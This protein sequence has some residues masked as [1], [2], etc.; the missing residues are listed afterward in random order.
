MGETVPVPA[1]PARSTRSAIGARTKPPCARAKSPSGTRGSGRGRGHI[2]DRPRRAWWT[3]S[4]RARGKKGLDKNQDGSVVWLFSPRAFSLY[5]D[6]K[7]TG[8]S[9]CL[10]LSRRASSKPLMPGITTSVTSASILKYSFSSS[11]NSGS[12][13]AKAFRRP[14]LFL[15]KNHPDNSTADS[16]QSG[17]VAPRQTVKG[18]ATP[19]LRGERHLQN[20]EPAVAKDRFLD[21]RGQTESLLILSIFFLFLSRRILL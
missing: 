7:T 15:G 3:Q 1:D 11:S 5:P 14:R 2:S 18:L 8:S 16:R 6:M 21:A 12:A 9:G 13:P 4:R 20:P 10:S 19:S 17:D